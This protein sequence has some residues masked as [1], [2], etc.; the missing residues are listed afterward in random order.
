MFRF[1][2]LFETHNASDCKIATFYINFAI[3]MLNLAEV[4]FV[5]FF[6]LCIPNYTVIDCVEFYSGGL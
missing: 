4:D 2:R 3:I 5:N 6:L 1:S